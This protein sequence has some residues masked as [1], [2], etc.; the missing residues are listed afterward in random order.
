MTTTVVPAVVPSDSP[1]THAVPVTE[2][3]TPPE[4]TAPPRALLPD[5]PALA[6]RYHALAYR[7]SQSLTTTERAEIKQDIIALFRDVSEATD[8]FVQFKDAVKALAAQWKTVTADQP[9]EQA[10]GGMTPFRVTPAV[11][12]PT[13]TG[14][15]DHLGAST[16]MEKGWSRLSLGDAVGAEEALRKA[17]ALAPND[18]DAECLL[19]WALMHQQ[20]YDSALLTFHNVLMRDPQHALA[21]ANVGFVCLRKGIY[22][23]AIEHLSRAIRAN[24]D[25]KATLYAH[26]YLGM[27]YRE[28]EMF[29]DAQ[30][31]FSR[32]LE[33]GPNLL[34]AWYESGR[35]Y[36]FA[37][38]F[39][40][41]R[42]AWRHGADANK[43]N[44]WGKRCA[45]M[46]SQ[47]DQGGSPPRHD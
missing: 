2:P 29:D 45:E 1:L 9:A 41:A 11:A 14:R 13:T 28:R 7:L 17:L 47:V 39:D 3:S 30:L 43:F 33:L 35:A 25:R 40:E 36:W 37:G 26:L 5:G 44:P 27:V 15:I 34:E 32:A 22:G 24:T 19:G 20:Q 31:F 38:K 4:P 6:E 12:G 8:Q 16:F 18:N 46:L 42:A 21:R 10:V 23:E